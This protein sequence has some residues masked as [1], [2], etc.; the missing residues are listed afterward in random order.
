MV[1]NVTQ[2]HIDKGIPF[3]VCACP[4][5]LAIKPHVKPR[6]YV[7]VKSYVIGLWHTNHTLV[8]SWDLPQA[9]QDF[10]DAFDCGKSVQPF[11]FELPIDH[12][13]VINHD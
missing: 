1:I 5:A 10:I 9:V 3:N 2:D 8:E 4:V 6:H 12:L 11:S 13:L 7:A